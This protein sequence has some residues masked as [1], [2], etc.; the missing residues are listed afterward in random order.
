MRNILEGQNVEIQAF[1]CN[2]SHLVTASEQALLRFFLRVL[3]H[4]SF[5]TSSQW[6]NGWI[7]PAQNR[8][9]QWNEVRKN[10]PVKKVRIV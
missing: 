10:N 4:C 9:S 1:L 2:T 7:C 5:H 3:L 6:A 8:D